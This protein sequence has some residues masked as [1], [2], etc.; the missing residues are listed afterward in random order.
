MISERAQSAQWHRQCQEVTHTVH[1]PILVLESRKHQLR[2]RKTS[3]N[4]SK[5]RL[6]VQGQ[7]H[8]AVAARQVEVEGGEVEEGVRAWLLTKGPRP[9]ARR[10]L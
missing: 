3:I 9:R 7:G 1:S 10:E 5:H 4:Y 2:V 8:A 6:E